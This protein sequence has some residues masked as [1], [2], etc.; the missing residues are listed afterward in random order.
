MKKHAYYV[1]SDIHLERKNEYKKNFLLDS[2]N[3]VIEDNKKQDIKT[4]IVFSGDVDNGLQGFDWL[5]K[6]QAEVIYVA[7][8]HEFWNNDYYTTIEQLKKNAPKHVHFL[9]NDFVECGDYIFVGS[10]MWTDVGKTLNDSLK[11]VS[12]GTMNDNYNITAKQWYTEKNIERIK[13]IIPQYHEKGIENYHWNILIEQE[14]N[15]KTIDFFNDFTKIRNQLLKLTEAYKNSD[16]D[17][18]RQ[19]GPLTKEHYDAIHKAMQLKQFTYHQWLIFC[20]QFDLLGYKQINDKMISSVSTEQET[21]F[22]NL[23]NINYTKE[24]IVVSHHLPF[25]EERLIGYY[26]H[27]ENSEKLINEKANNSIYT[28]RDGLNDYPYHN[29]FYRISKGEFSRSE[30]I[31]E[32]IH[33]SNNGAVNLPRDLYENAKAWCHGHDHTLNYQDYVKGVNIVTN[34]LSYSLD[35][36]KFAE[37]GIFLHDTYKTYHKIQTEEQEQHEVEKLRKLVLKPININ[38]L[39]NE[40]DMIKLWVFNL[41]DKENFVS[42]LES[43]SQ[44]NKKFFTYM[45]KNPQFSI[46]EVNDKSYQKIQEFTFANYYYFNEINKILDTLDLAYAARFDN[47][48]SYMNK[49]N[50]HYSKHITKHVYSDESKIRVENFSKQSIEDYGYDYLTTQL[51]E[52]IYYLNKSIKRVKHIISVCENHG[53]IESITQLFNQELPELYPKEKNEDYFFDRQLYEKKHKIMSKYITEDIE[54]IK[55]QKRKEKFYF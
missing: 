10:T 11:Y 47:D 16:K 54:K 43:F 22:K 44:N 30:S 15:Q 37:N 29:Y 25:L 26:S 46:G 42:L 23:A 5:K 18:K 8:N 50:K 1:I 55:E 3:L 35:V 27:I 20:K 17:L 21:V 24:I 39:K 14:E 31:L 4:V 7:G 2:I 36:F 41:M 51:F 28:I 52:N 38:H 49:V 33:Y 34:P 9:H 12:N 6:I 13:E 53:E 32:A 45:A 40:D 48:F 19:Y